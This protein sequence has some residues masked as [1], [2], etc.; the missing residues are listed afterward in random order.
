[1]KTPGVPA[2]IAFSPREET[3]A[4]DCNNGFASL[5]WDI[6]SDGPAM[7][8]M[9]VRKDGGGNSVAWSRDGRLVAFAW[10]WGFSVREVE[11]TKVIGSRPH[12]GLPGA[13]NEAPAAFSPDGAVLAGGL[14]LWDVAGGKRLHA[15]RALPLTALGPH[16][17]GPDVE[18]L[19]FHPRTVTLAVADRRV[20]YLRIWDFGADRICTMLTGFDGPPSWH[21][22]FTSE[23]HYRV[24]G[25]PKDEVVYVVQ[26][27]DGQQATL[28]AGDFS[29]K[30]G[31]KNDPSKV[32][33]AGEP[34]GQKPAEKALPPKTAD[35][36]KPAAAKP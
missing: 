6:H 30:Y 35:G 9:P 32:T 1:L 15:K 13:G 18:G 34:S 23:G 14:N 3:V 7:E 8:I 31:W 5:L 12:L 16:P 21:L 25:E 29:R 17:V 10:L 24:V 36:P 19:S 11:G 20:P 33:L 4:I 22:A 27:A 26:T 28:T 2:A